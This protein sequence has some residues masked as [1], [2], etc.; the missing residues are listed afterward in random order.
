MANE[1]IK[2]IQRNQTTDQ[3]VLLFFELIGNDVC[4]GHHTFDTVQI[5]IFFKKQK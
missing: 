1:V 3:P 4:N 5:M 2:A